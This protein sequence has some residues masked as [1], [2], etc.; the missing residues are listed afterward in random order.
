[1]PKMHADELEID[2]ALVRA[3]ID[4]QFPEWAGLPLTRVEPWGHRQRHLS[5]RRGARRAFAATRWRE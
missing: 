5:S 2:E 3:L 1:M 4:E